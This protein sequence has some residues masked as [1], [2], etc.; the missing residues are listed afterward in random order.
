MD[1]QTLAIKTNYWSDLR[2][3]QST[4][5][6][7]KVKKDEI[8]VQLDQEKIRQQIHNF[9]HELRLLEIDFQILEVE[10]KLAESLVPLEMEAI[11]LNEKYVQEDFKRFKNQDLPFQKRCGH[12]FGQ[13][14]SGFLIAVS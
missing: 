3:V 9:S 6:G 14:K 12:Q 7:K 13:R 8:L 1:A 4:K 2:V 5:Q 11:E 10:L